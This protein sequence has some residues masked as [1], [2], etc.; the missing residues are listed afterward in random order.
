MELQQQPVSH[1][2]HQAP[3]LQHSGEE[4]GKRT[5]PDFFLLR[6]RLVLEGS[7][8]L[9]QSPRAGWAILL[10]LHLEV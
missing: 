7:L 10:E 2:F 1:I 3:A 9:G 5:L 6:P 8:M 4:N